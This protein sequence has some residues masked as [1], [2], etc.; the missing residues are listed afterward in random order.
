MGLVVYTT[1]LIIYLLR[2]RR[3]CFDLNEIEWKQFKFAGEFL[4]TGYLMHYLPY[5]FVERTLF[6]HHYFP[7]FIYKILL[8][9]Y[10]IEHIQIILKK[11]VNFKLLLYLYKMFLFLW[12]CSIIFVYIKFTVLCYGTTKLTVDDIISLRWRDTWDFILHKD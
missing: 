12:L 5:F 2:R 11:N 1:L 10:L 6:L 8:L 9:C 3:M 7:A 4:L